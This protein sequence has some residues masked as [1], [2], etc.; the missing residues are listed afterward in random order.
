MS[1]EADW[2]RVA[3]TNDPNKWGADALFRF[4]G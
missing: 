2:V 4:E 1:G 3:V